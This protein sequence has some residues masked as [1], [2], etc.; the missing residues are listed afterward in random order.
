MNEREQYEE[1]AC[2]NISSMKQLVI[3]QNSEG[4]LVIAKRFL[5]NDDEEGEKKIFEKGATIIRQQYIGGFVD[6]LK[7]VENFTK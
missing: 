5:V 7:K 6:L 4:S 1:I 3:S 2:C